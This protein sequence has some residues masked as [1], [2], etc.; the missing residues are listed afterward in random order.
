MELS[1]EELDKLAFLV[2]GLPPVAYFVKDL[3]PDY[4]DDDE[5]PLIGIYVCLRNNPRRKLCMCAI[6]PNG[7]QFSNME[8][9]KHYTLQKLGL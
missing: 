3:I 6:L 8:L 9:G 2:D 5:E 1:K 7:L 4:A